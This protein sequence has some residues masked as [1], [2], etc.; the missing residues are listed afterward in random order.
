MESGSTQQ[1]IDRFHCVLQ[2]FLVHLTDK[3]SKGA[4]QRPKHV[5]TW[6]GKAIHSSSHIQLPE[7]I[8]EGGL[9]AVMRGWKQYLSQPVLPASLAYVLLYFNAVLAPGG[10]MTTYLSQ[11]GLYLTC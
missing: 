3:S 2:L 6:D 1:V 9:H 5:S 11:Q 8:G 4:L 7:A 10:L